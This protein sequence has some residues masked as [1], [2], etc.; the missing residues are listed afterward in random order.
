[1][2]IGRNSHVSGWF[3]RSNEDL[4]FNFQDL[5]EQGLDYLE[6]DFYY[7]FSVREERYYLFTGALPETFAEIGVVKSRR[8]IFDEHP[9]ALSYLVLT[10]AHVNDWPARTK[11]C[12][13]CGSETALRND[14]RAK[15]C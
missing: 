8:T 4:L 7:L 10:A 9:D 12:G 6:S 3:K 2:K 5:R 1:M 14:E 11:F 13:A 15:T